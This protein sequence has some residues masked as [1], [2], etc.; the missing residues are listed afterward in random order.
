MRAVDGNG[1]LVP[2]LIITSRPKPSSV[3]VIVNNEKSAG[4]LT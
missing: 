2:F 1:C 4:S 3:R